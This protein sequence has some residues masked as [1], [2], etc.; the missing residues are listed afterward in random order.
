LVQLTKDDVIR[1]S[2]HATTMS[3]PSDWETVCARRKRA[4]YDSIPPEWIIE[5]PPKDQ[6]NVMDVPRQS[7]L[8]DDLE[9]EI[10]ETVDVQT[11]LDKLRSAEWSS[12]QVTTAF[13]KR[14]IIVQ[15]LVCGH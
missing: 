9:L 8:L 12:V 11:I 13:Y 7:G 5:P 2:L 14:A 1:F 15:Q 3:F 10:T 4:Q 6:L